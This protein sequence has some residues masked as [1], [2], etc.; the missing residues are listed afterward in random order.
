MVY[1][2]S[3]TAYLSRDTNFK[4]MVDR[5]VSNNS[6]DSIVAVLGHKR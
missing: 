4:L 1:N 5:A 2:I 6:A 3:P